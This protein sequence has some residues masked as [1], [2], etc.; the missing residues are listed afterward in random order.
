[1]TDENQTP[2]PQL[3]A[4]STEFLVGQIALYIRMALY[5]AAGYLA[6][7]SDAIAWDPATGTL[8]LNIDQG[9]M[10]LATATAGFVATYLWS[11]AAKSR[12]GA[13]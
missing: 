4:P 8:A 2:E 5:P 11:R 6:A 7:Q 12:G 3:P 10:L 1:M 13:T 9:A